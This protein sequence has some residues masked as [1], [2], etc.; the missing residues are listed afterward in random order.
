MRFTN[1][2]MRFSGLT[3]P[4]HHHLN[5]TIFPVVEVGA[6]VGSVGSS[7][8]AVSLGSITAL[9]LKIA[10]SSLIASVSPKSSPPYEGGVR[11]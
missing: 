2:D 1:P 7:V 11:L 5:P 8:V 10:V 9:M 6:Q 4:A 3:I